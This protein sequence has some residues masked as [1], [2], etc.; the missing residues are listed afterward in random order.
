MK[1]PKNHST[2]VNRRDML[3][4]ATMTAGGLI[5]GSKT[6]H[7]EDPQS[8]SGRAFRYCLNTSTIRGQKLGIVEEI[9]I[10]G[11]AG[12]DAMEPWFDAL[13]TYVD[14]GGSLKDLK[15]RIADHGMTIESAIGFAPWIVNDSARRKKG[16][17]QAR[18][19]MDMLAQIGGIRMAAPPAGA[20]GNDPIAL[21]DAAKRYREL[22]EAGESIGVIPQIEM[23]GGHPIIGRISTALSI[24]IEC[25]HPK[26]CFLGDVYHTYKGGCPFEG[27]KLLGP[28][29]MQVFHFNDYPADPPLETI[30]DEHRVYPGDGIA[31]LDDILRG[32]VEVGATP[33][34]SLEVFNRSYWAQ[35]AMLTARTGLQKMKTAVRNALG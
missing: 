2:Q 6:M 12:Y 16:L 9:E 22:L 27:L 1:Q 31:P 32:F 19:E 18:R 7:A 23:W 10:A 14:G 30:K 28:Q 3:T 5:L 8:P 26:A 13:H 4:A 29:A 17:E 24:A 21:E 35:D 15:K 25:G 20:P 34:L 33:V 11:K